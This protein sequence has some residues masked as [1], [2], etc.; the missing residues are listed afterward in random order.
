MTERLQKPRRRL[1]SVNITNIDEYDLGDTPDEAIR[2]FEKFKEYEREGSF[3]NLKI[4]IFGG[5]IELSGERLETDGELNARIRA[6]DHG[7]DRQKKEKERTA[8]N[9]LK[10]YEKLKEKYESNE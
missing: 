10:L 9:E 3:S 2:E 4:N 6:Y 7:K 8:K 1:I 5:Y